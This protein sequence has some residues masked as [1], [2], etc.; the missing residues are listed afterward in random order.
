MPPRGSRLLS[1]V[2]AARAGGGAEVL[3]FK[4]SVDELSRLSTAR[5]QDEALLQQIS[6]QLHSLEPAVCA[7]L[8]TE[9]RFRDEWRQEKCE[10]ALQQLPS[11]EQDPETVDRMREYIAMLAPDEDLGPLEPG[12]QSE[13][14]RQ[15]RT[16]ASLLT[17]CAGGSSDRVQ[18]VL[19]DFMENS[20]SRLHAALTSVHEEL[21]EAA[22]SGHCARAPARVSGCGGGL[23]PSSS[24]LKQQPQ[25]QPP[26][27]RSAPGAPHPIYAEAAWGGAPPQLSPRHVWGSETEA[28]A[29]PGTA[30]VRGAPVKPG[31]PG[32]STGGVRGLSAEGFVAQ[33]RGQHRAVC[34]IQ[35]AVRGR[36]MRAAYRRRVNCRIGAAVRLQCCARR[37]VARRALR[38]QRERRVL[39]ARRAL[40]EWHAARRVQRAWRWARRKRRWTAA[41]RAQMAHAA[42]A[43]DKAWRAML[44]RSLLPKTQEATG[45]SQYALYTESKVLATRRAKEEGSAQRLQ[46]AVR[47][48]KVRV[49]WRKLHRAASVLQAGVRRWRVCN[50]ECPW[51]RALR[52]HHATRRSRR[53]WRSQRAAALALQPLQTR[54]VLVQLHVSKEL[55]H[56]YEEVLREKRD[57]ESA[58]RKWAAKMEK[59]TLA[60][61]LHA[62]WIPQMNVERGES[63]FFNVRTGE[64]SEEHPNMKEVRKTEK[65]QRK[66]A[67]EA[68]EERLTRLQGYEEQLRDALRTELE[69]YAEQAAKVAA[70]AAVLAQVAQQGIRYVVR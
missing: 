15:Q 66:L 43:D 57:F 48:L 54:A 58:F 23:S 49:L 26:P 1:S 32:G 67:E 62:D 51:R 61:K 17:L 38:V 7:R 52:R 10:R 33:L 21:L 25:P 64:S 65:K 13:L 36:R 34:T 63:Y 59:L 55:E 20:R 50:R 18:T 60:K 69:A 4:A 46:A 44:K 19:S 39:A 11:S 41:W 31:G 2:L 35:A 42:G 28:A 5:A 12:W 56:V 47:A 30:E 53:R 24:P 6:A 40:R 29:R 45:F 14:L 70:E 37:W 3:A 16:L 8:L 9:C 27:F 22:A 68:M